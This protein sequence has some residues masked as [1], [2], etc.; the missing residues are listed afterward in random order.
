MPR[1]LAAR[2]M[3]LVGLLAGSMIGP[4]AT[5]AVTTAT[6]DHSPETPYYTQTITFTFVTSPDA[7][8]GTVYFWDADG[9]GIHP[10]G[11][12]EYANGQA[13]FQLGAPLLDVGPAGVYATWNGDGGVTSPTDT[14]TIVGEPSQVTMEP[15]FDVPEAGDSFRIRARASSNYH[16]DGGS[17]TFYRQG[18]ATPLCS[19]VSVTQYN[20]PA[21][22]IVPGLPAGT[23][24]FTATFSGTNR[25][26]G[27]TGQFQ[28]TVLANRLLAS[29]VGVQYSSVYPVVDGYRDTSA[30]RGVREEPLT[31][32]I[33]IYHPTGALHKTVNLP[34]GTG[35]Y[36]YAWNGRNSAGTIL[37][38]GKYK[39][40]Q[41]LK[42]AYGTTGTFTAYI[43]LSK[44]KLYTYTKV[45]TQ[46][47]SSIDAI[48]TANNGAVS[49]NTTAGY[50]KLSTPMVDVSWAAVGWQFAMPT[51]T[52]YTSFYVRVYGRHTGTTGTTFL[53]AQN[54]VACPYSS[55][56]GW[57]E[58]C[59]G[60]WVEI[61][62]TSG[63][64]LYYRRTTGLS[65]A[66][67][68]GAK[69]RLLVSSYGGTTLIYK[70]QV[71]VTY[72][73]LKY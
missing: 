15:P 43:T 37:A 33:R 1:I 4:T 21:D 22:C 63:T 49:V 35:A 40:V 53:G 68:S 34:Q 58:E 28:L 56:A 51:A 47:G 6:L 7:G 31:V 61:P 20:G 19:D 55:T 29:G 44:K 46:A 11:S 32:T 69:V 25:V 42:D 24:T 71:V 5:L 23:Y 2:V 48:G 39:I 12:A 9:D 8:S 18:V 52:V 27:S 70:A 66:Y 54:F 3:L 65:S 17:M 62:T 38:E 67:R 10:L 36:S 60:S 64:T 57:Q 14:F 50:A 73:L 45:L 41:T 72:G 13:V 59:F 30:I 26:A 16:E